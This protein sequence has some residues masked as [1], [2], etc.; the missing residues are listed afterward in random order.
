M[1]NFPTFRVTYGN[2]VLNG[3]VAGARS[4]GD[5]FAKGEGGHDVFLVIDRYC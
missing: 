2:G 4:P 3:E 5:A 1:Y